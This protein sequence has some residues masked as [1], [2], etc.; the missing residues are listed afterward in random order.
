[1]KISGVQNMG[2]TATVI[3]RGSNKMV[4]EEAVRSMHDAL[5]VVRCLVH[6]SFLVAGGA[7]A[8]V[9]VA[10]QLSNWAK[11]LEVRLKCANPV[12]HWWLHCQHTSV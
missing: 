7:A 8:E 10:Y 9:E 3:M 4:L 6:K 12:S 2:R 5:C 1:M 11:T